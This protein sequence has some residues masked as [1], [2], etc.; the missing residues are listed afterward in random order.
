V[1]L[2]A[3]QR[4]LFLF[5]GAIVN[6]SMIS[7]CAESSMTST[8]ATNLMPPGE[9]TVFSSV[10]NDGGT[11]PIDYTCDGSSLSPP[12]S[13]S[14][15]PDGTTNFAVLMDHQPGTGDWHWYWTLWSIDA[16]TSELD[17]GSNG[18]AI[19]GA[20][21]VN[22]KLIYAP[23]CSQ[24]PG[25][26][27]YD[28]SIYALSAEPSLN[29]PSNVDRTTFLDAIADITLATDTMTVTYSRS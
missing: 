14:D 19:V 7:A 4:R 16:A 26:K 11:L 28:I 22:N 1:N 24:G 21:S 3:L 29:N 8:T 5:A 23:P 6:L 9:F 10:M 15:A 2:P 25:E 12:I 13:W 27:A 17:A 20:N 18:D